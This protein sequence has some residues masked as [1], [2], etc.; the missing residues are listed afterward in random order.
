M[1]TDPRQETKRNRRYHVR[2]RALFHNP[3]SLCDYVAAIG[4]GPFSSNHES[5]KSIELAVLRCTAPMRQENGDL[6][7]PGT[8]P[9][10]GKCLRLRD[11]AEVAVT[12]RPSAATSHAATVRPHPHDATSHDASRRHVLA[13]WAHE[14]RQRRRWVALLFGS[15]PI[16]PAGSDPGFRSSARTCST[17]GTHPG[18]WCRHGRARRS[19]PSDRHTDA[20]GCGRQSRSMSGHLPS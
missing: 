20:C 18:P 2:W 9:I 19:S 16:T 6:A 15:D 7:Y 17:S 1:S 8:L 11:G 14:A 5:A 4:V 3:R 12:M 10:L 13:A